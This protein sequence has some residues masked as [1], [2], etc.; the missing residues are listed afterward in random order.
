MAKLRMKNYSP[1]QLS[2]G[3]YGSRRK[4]GARKHLFSIYR[5]GPFIAFLRP[6]FA[7]LRQTYYNNKVDLKFEHAIQYGINFGEMDVNDGKVHK[8]AIWIGLLHII[9][10]V[11]RVAAS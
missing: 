9:H 2:H 7:A 8:W 5:K 3:P 10:P 4:I 6:M 1:L 11:Q